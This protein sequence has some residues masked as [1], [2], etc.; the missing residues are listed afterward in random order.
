M[1]SFFL[2]RSANVQTDEEDTWQ[3]DKCEVYDFVWKIT[4][5]DFHLYDV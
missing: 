3:N 4:L 1:K 2:A 5:L